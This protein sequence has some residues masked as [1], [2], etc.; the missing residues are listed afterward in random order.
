VPTDHS[1]PID[2]TVLCGQPPMTGPTLSQQRSREDVLADAI[3]VLTEAARLTRP[4][5]RREETA[6]AGPGQLGWIDSGRR[7]P[8]DWAEF[9]T[10]A[11]AG[12]A[13]NI[14]G[15]ETILAGRP[16]SW[17]ADGVRSLLAATV[18]PDEQYL[19][20]HRTEPLVIELNIDELLVDLG[21]WNPYD[22]ANRELARRYDAIGIPTATGVPS[23][24]TVDALTR[25]EPASEKQERQAD[26]IA[27]LEERLEQQRL[28]DWAAYGQ[29]LLAAVEAEA[30]RLPGLTVPVVVRLDLD[31][32]RRADERGGESWGLA[33]RLREAATQVTALPGD[34]RP[35]LERLQP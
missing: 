31:T 35:P 23:A 19:L 27:E 17:E 18:G 6:A 29:A 15:I 26:E 28:Q 30:A 22:D 3:R 7:E 16:G 14:G 12:A 20:E 2:P 1:V 13:A 32:F 24:M 9:V 21:A 10:H 33:D 4:V 25:L 11:L 8:A 5:L 34:E